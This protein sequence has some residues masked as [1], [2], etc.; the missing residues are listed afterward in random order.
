MRQ[1]KIIY[2]EEGKVSLHGDSKP[3]KLSN[4]DCSRYKE[5]K[6]INQLREARL[7]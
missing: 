1:R 7:Q 4:T 3:Y 2:E 5:N 6:I